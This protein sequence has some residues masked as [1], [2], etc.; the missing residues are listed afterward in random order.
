MKCLSKENILNLYKHQVIRGIA[1]AWHG[2]YT[3]IRGLSQHC[4]AKWRYL[5]NRRNRKIKLVPQR[6]KVICNI[7]K[8]WYQMLYE[9]KLLK[10]K[11]THF[12][13]DMRCNV[14]NE[15]LKLKSREWVLFWIKILKNKCNEIC[16]LFYYLPDK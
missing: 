6:I 15:N 9:I 11:H 4:V 12:K 8:F 1:Y 13:F 10:W 2:K 16:L 14:K 5:V 3:N 7:L